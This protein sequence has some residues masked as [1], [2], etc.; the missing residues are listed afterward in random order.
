MQ[1]TVAELAAV[2]GLSVVPQWV[3][4]V[5]STQ[6]VVRAWLAEGRPAGLAAITD[7][8][9]GG[10]GRLGRVWESPPGSGVQLSLLLRPVLPP[11]RLGL[12]SLAA[13][14][15]VR[16]VIGP[17]FGIKWPNDLLGPHGKV[18]GI[19]AEADGRGGLI[20]GIGI[21]V[22][23]APGGV[24]AST[25]AATGETRDA[26]AIGVAVIAAVVDRVG[27]LA[28]PSSVLTAWREADATRGR[29]LV[30][31]GRAGVGDGIDDD[32]ALRLRQE[33]GSIHRVVA[34]DVEMVGMLSGY[35]AGDNPPS[36]GA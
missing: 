30:V 10:R 22:S 17:R 1:S 21:N 6:D 7:R 28:A 25:L 32:G 8:Q 13:A 3:G 26:L 14:V 5:D 33:D 18:A 31:A 15:A 20:L 11:A 4:E 29:S 2:H 23:A 27:S 35:S 36:R 24:G 16:D 34:G 12:V 19:L 9:R